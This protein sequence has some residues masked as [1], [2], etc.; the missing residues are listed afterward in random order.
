[1][2]HCSLRLLDDIEWETYAQVLTSI[3]HER[4]VLSAKAM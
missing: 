1:M 2:V 3:H 4:F